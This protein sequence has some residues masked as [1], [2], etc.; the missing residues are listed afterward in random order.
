MIGAYHHILELLHGPETRRIR[1]K[2]ILLMTHPPLSLIVFDI[3]PGCATLW[4]G[5][6]R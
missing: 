3:Q 2:S 5:V 1:F 4:K 6:E